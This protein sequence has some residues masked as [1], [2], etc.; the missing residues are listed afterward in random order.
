MSVID[1]LNPNRFPDISGKM[2]AVVSC[3]L[4]QDWAVPQIKS[5][6][7]SPD[8]TAW[9]MNEGDERYG[10][11]VGNAIEV[12]R[13]WKALLADADLTPEERKEAERLYEEVITD[14]RSESMSQDFYKTVI[15]YQQCGDF[16]TSLQ[17][18]TL[19]IIDIVK[20]IVASGGD[21]PDVAK[22]PVCRVW[23]EHLAQLAGLG[24]CK[25][26]QAVQEALEACKGR[27]A[28]AARSFH[29]WRDHWD[30]CDEEDEQ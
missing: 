1:K 12:E 9:A 6:W 10:H 3:I 13:E 23:V 29:D 21:T 2:V 14:L 25:E 27:A 19:D 11:Y 24:G 28:A 8:G 30:S 16:T 22:H 17:Q 4:R 15:D 26:T 20:E 18:F 5:L 7:F